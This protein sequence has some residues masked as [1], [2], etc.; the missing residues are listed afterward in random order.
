MERRT[1]V[2][3]V[4]SAAFAGTLAG[5]TG[6]GS[7]NDGPSPPAEDANPKELLPDAPEGLTRTQSQQQSAGMV[8][9]EAGYS[10]GYDDEDGNH[11]AVEILRWS[12]KKDAK[13]KG[14]GVYSDGWSVYVVLG[15]FGFAAKGPDVETAKELLANSSALTKQ[16]VENNNLNA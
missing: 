13:D 10:A 11:Y 7:G 15:N 9:A 1:F 16:Y 8:G 14:S 12:S 2:R 5:C 6:G 3:G 4:A